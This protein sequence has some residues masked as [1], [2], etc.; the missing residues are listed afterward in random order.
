MDGKDGVKTEKWEER[1][2]IDD[3]RSRSSGLLNEN[4]NS[5]SIESLFGSSTIRIFLIF[6]YFL[7]FLSL[8][9]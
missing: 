6:Q 9:E 2:E 8:F 5:Q 4:L 1:H 3:L 7:I